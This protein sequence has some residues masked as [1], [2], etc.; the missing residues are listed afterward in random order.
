[1]QDAPAQLLVDVARLAPGGETVEGEADIADVQE[2]F[3]KA[4]GPMRYR[5]F[6]QAF[7]TEVVARGSLA[8]DFRFVCSRCGGDFETTIE[9]SDFSASVETGERDQFADL[10]AEARDSI[11]LEIPNFPVCG[12][13]CP[14]TPQVAAGGVPDGRWSALD[15]LSAPPA[16]GKRKI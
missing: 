9:K 12:E 1:M 8:Q 14:G 13:D 10:T 5:L 3:V 2:E 15:A 7:G 4:S 16:E 11:I 6:V